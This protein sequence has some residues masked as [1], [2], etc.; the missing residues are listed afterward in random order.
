MLLLFS[1]LV[2]LSKFFIN[3]IGSSE[4]NQSFCGFFSSLVTQKPNRRF[5]DKKQPKNQ[6]PIENNWEASYI[7]PVQHS[8]K[9]IADQ[10]SNTNHQSKE[11]QEGPSPPSRAVLGHQHG[12]VSCA[13]TGAEPTQH[14]ASNQNTKVRGEGDAKPANNRWESRAHHCSLGAKP[15]TAIAT[16]ETAEYR[17]NVDTAG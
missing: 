7:S 5:W 3:F 13:H 6:T 15:A 2:N 1:C 17:A 12:A 9:R 10:D 16:D 8:S 11:G 14:S 4:P